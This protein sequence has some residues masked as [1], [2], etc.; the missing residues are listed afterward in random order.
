MGEEA[1]ESIIAAKE[2][3]R[4]KNTNEN[5]DKLAHDLVY[6]V[7]DTWFHQMVALSKL[8]LS[9]QDVIDE[10]AYRFGIS[11]IEEK[12]TVVQN[13]TIITLGLLIFLMTIKTIKG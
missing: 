6:E 1:V 11:G 7:A 5:C 10:L 2:L 12:K 3:E 8:G 4:A 9:A 13:S